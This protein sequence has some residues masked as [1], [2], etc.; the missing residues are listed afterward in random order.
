MN[1]WIAA[2]ALCAGGYLVGRVRPVRRVRD[3]SAWEAHQVNVK[4]GWRGEAKALL[5]LS[6]NPDLVAR[7]LWKRWRS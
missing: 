2:V 6:L 7:Y 4:P 1:V 5:L 3:W